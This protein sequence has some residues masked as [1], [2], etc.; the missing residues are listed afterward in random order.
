MR[1][2]L[3][4]LLFTP[5]LWAD[6]NALLLEVDNNYFFHFSYNDVNFNCEAAAITTLTQFALEHND[7]KTCVKAINN[8]FTREPKAPKMHHYVLH[9]DI[10]Y[11][12]TPLD[13]KCFVM[14]NG[15]TSWSEYL[16]EKGY[17]VLESNLDPMFMLSAHYHQLERAQK[18]AQY[19]KRGL[20]SDIMIKNCLGKN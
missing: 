20:W 16:I 13:K 11:S 5:F 9:E 12:I 15:G 17:A 8:F 18:R 3:F 19:H 2:T 1:Q 7:S 14:L 10:T 4:T 6:F